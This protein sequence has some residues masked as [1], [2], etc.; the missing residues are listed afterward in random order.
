MST[1]VQIPRRPVLRA[2]NLQIYVN[3]KS[4]LG[5]SRHCCIISSDVVE[6]GK[7]PSLLSPSPLVLSQSPWSS[8]EP[9][10]YQ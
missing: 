1:C 3:W 10:D 7:T 5:V 6:S 4:V 9:T 2:Q 8:E